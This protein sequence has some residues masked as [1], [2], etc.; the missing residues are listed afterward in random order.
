M[1]IGFV[2]FATTAMFVQGFY[3]G[4]NLVHSGDS[5]PGNVVTTFWSALMATK[6]FE[7]ILPHIIV[8][9]KGRGAAI[10]LRAVLSRVGKC[11]KL[12]EWPGGFNPKFVDGDIEVRNISFAY[13]S[14]PEHLV[15]QESTIFFPAGETTFIVG[16]SGSRKSTLNNLLMRFYPP[17]SGQI[18]IDGQTLDQLSMVWL[19]NN[20][21]LVQQQSIL[22]NETIFKNIAF[23]AQDHTRV[24]V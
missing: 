21:T 4:G 14:R 10:A 19:R 22:F 3:Y 15:L 5:T 2:R 24:T 6:A 17:A 8:L 1:Q 7:D 12:P 20:I 13:P 9:E 11:K 23:G 16:K 18:F